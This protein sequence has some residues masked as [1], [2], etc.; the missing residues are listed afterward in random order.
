SSRRRHTRFS[1]DWSSD[2]CSSDLLADRLGRPLLDPARINARLDAVAFFLERRRLREQVRERLRAA[3]DMA[4][5]LS[6]LALGRGGP[7][8][9]SGERRV[10]REWGAGGATEGWTE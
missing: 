4:R 8:D 1:R 6:R 2:V 5:A 9:R 10:G 3:G 7:R